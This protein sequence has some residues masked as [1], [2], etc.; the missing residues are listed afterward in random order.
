MHIPLAGLQQCNARVNR[1]YTTPK[2]HSG[3]SEIIIFQLHS[4][5]P[6]IGFSVQSGENHILI[7]FQGKG[8]A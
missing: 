5:N 8:G 3:S 1:W 4:L 7:F 2:G 6:H